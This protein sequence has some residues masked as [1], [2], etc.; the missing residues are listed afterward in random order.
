MNVIG[1]RPDG[2]WRDRPAAQ[3]Q[4]VGALSR[5]AQGEEEVT[6]VFDGRARQ[7]QAP[8][9]EVEVVFAPGG[10]NAADDE[11]IRRLEHL[12]AGDQPVVVTSDA[13]LAARVRHMGVEVESAG[14][15]RTRLGI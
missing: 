12:V 1:T 6:V 15:F 14:R 9:P 10:P 11:I 7:A 4:L 3:Q 5:W 8:D 2:W 13:I